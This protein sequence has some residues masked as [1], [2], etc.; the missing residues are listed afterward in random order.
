MSRMSRI[1]I[2]ILLHGKREKTVQKYEKIK[3]EP[4]LKSR[5]VWRKMPKYEVYSKYLFFKK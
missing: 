5:S 3:K 4:Y 1:R 2:S